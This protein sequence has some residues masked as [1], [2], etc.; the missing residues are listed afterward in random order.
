MP[1]QENFPNIENNGD[2]KYERSLRQ[3]RELLESAPAVKVLEIYSDLSDKDRQEAGRELK[4]A[5]GNHP[6]VKLY[7]AIFKQYSED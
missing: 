5:L 1:K 7:R 2:G 3:M 4:E 6:D